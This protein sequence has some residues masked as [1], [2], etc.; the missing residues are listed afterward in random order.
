MSAHLCT[1]PIRP[2]CGRI[3]RIR[4]GLR[5]FHHF[6]SFFQLTVENL[7]DQFSGRSRLAENDLAVISCK[8]CRKARDKCLRLHTAA[9]LARIRNVCSVT[10][11]LSASS[12]RVMPARARS[13]SMFFS[14]YIPSPPLT[15]ASLAA[16]LAVKMSIQELRARRRSIRNLQETAFVFPISKGLICYTTFRL[17]GRYTPVK[18]HLTSSILKSSYWFRNYH[19]LNS[20][21]LG[22]TYII[23]QC[24][25]NVKRL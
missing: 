9:V 15:S 6:Q 21:F 8:P 22:T 24:F 23:I 11:K 5:A 13:A 2:F 18:Y 19:L 16:F 1:T 12:L 7:A 20:N 3:L 4:Y 25:W 10:F 14:G 17:F